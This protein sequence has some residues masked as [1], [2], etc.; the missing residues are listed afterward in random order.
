[1]AVVTNQEKE[2]QTKEH[3]LGEN[4]S[5]GDTEFSELG[6]G[7]LQDG[8]PAVELFEKGL[9]ITYGDYLVLPGFIDFHPREVDLETNL[10]RTIRIKRPLISSPMDTVTGDKMAIAMALLGGI[11]IV[12][13]NNTINE[14]TEMVRNVKR[15]KNG[16]IMEPKVMGPF[17]KIRDIDE[18][19]ARY[20][21]SGIPITEDG[22]RDS[23]LIGIVTNRDVDMETD[24]SIMLGQVMTKELITAPVGMSL[25]EANQI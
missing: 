11:G 19:K 9:G 18:I 1:M 5:L 12:H 24:R 6:S 20:G 10:T 3:P 14:Q 8:Q 22:T 15:Y 23:R 21:F 16:F 17:H 13:Y 4:G 2:N 7:L 25:T